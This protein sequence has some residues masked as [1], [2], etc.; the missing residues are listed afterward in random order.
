MKSWKI[1]GLAAVLCAALALSGGPAV[2][3]APAQALEAGAPVLVGLNYGDNVLDG[4]NLLNEVGEGYRF[5]RF[6]EERNFIQLGM[7]DEKAVSVVMT[8]NVWYGSSNGY[9]SYSDDITSEIL[10]G[11]YHA[12]ISGS[13]ESF[14]EAQAAADSVGGF[15][16]WMGESGGYR[17]RVGSYATRDEAAQAA[18]ALGGS[19]GETSA[20]GL[21]VVKTGSSRIL[22]QFDAG[23]GGA[24]CVLPGLDDEVRTVTWFKNRRYFGGFHY[25]RLERMGMTVSNFLPLEEYI[26]CV[27]SQEMSP[28]WPIEALKAQAVCARTYYEIN[29]GRHTGFDICPE[30]HCQAYPGM[31]KVNDATDQAAAETAGIRAWYD[32][33]L[34]QTFYFSSDG[35]ATEAPK[36]VWGSKEELPYLQGVRDP[37]ETAIADVIQKAY[38]SRRYRW[39]Y[40][41]TRAEL[42]ELLRS[43]GYQCKEITDFRVSEYTPSGNPA[44]LVFT[45]SS[46]TNYSFSQSKIV[47]WL[48]LPAYC[49]TL[50]GGGQYYVD[51]NGSTL[52]SLSGV[53]VIGGDGRT[54]A[55]D[56]G[57]L[58]YIIT[59]S[60]VEQLAPVG[61]DVFT[62]SGGGWGHN[63]G[64]SQWGAYAMAQQGMTYDEILKF[65][66]TGI[67][68]Y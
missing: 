10:V 56:G 4:A 5:G 64:M 44:T 16:A 68:L 19:V 41:Y 66:Y 14:E 32:G 29:L 21:S 61:G 22:F 35:G 27:V 7:T 62:I 3:A 67:E 45:D 6:D 42:A 50:S 23:E 38:G 1:T 2:L 34:A 24:L 25:Q 36:Y 9:T 48:K 63:V 33:K 54:T 28:S 46:G 18:A 55:L 26:S 43:K 15:V 47:S 60:G 53:F 13:Y 31:S 12:E 30:T 37:Y 57:D 39:T 17:V 11:C 58:P 49:Y 20:Y 8:R 52:G 65:Y 40:T 59:S 51:G